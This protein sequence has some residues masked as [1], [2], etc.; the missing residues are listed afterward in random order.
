MDDTTNPLLT[1]VVRAENAARDRISGAENEAKNELR[2]ARERAEELVKT[3]EFKAREEAR[4]AVE[5]AR[6]SGEVEAGGILERNENEIETM[7]KKARGRMK[8]T[9][10]AIVERITGT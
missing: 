2:A 6:R 9:S 5:D 10:R 7:K 3:A 4:Q 8:E 1:P